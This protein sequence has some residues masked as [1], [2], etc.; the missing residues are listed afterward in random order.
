MKRRLLALFILVMAIQGCSQSVK[1]DVKD[2]G[3]DIKN[4]VNK[5]TD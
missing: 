1:E 3:Q 2:L 4:E 5:A